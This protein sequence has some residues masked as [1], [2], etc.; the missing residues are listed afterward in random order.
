MR[1]R[2]GHGPVRQRLSRRHQF[3]L[4]LTSA[5]LLISGIG[6]LVSH[7]LLR[8]VGPFGE[9][10]SPA[11]PW[12]LRLHGAAVLSFLVV[13][14]A[15]LPGHVIQSW[16][17]RRSHYSGG[18]VV[19]IVA[20]LGLTGYGLYYAVGDTLREWVGVIHW[21]LGLAAAMTLGAHVLLARRRSS[22]VHA[23]RARH[24]ERWHANRAGSEPAPVRVSAQR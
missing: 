9:L 3:W 23:E 7:Y 14:G 22:Q 10:P 21:S 13:F 15:T 19:L 17:Q 4:Y 11:E 5:G 16:R 8:S 1:R 2:H 20:A 18:A 6:W 12:W 24:V